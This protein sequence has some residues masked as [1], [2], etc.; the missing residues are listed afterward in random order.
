MKSK[1]NSLA[2]GSVVM[3]LSIDQEVL[4]LIPSS[5]IFLCSK[6]IPQNVLTGYFV[7]HCP[8][9]MFCPELF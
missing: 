7:F 8:L 5:G 3:S 9:S 6:I 1:S 2:L 4:D